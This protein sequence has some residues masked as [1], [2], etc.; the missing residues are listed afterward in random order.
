MQ[1]YNKY[2]KQVSMKYVLHYE[3]IIH[4]MT[5]E[6]SMSHMP[7]IDTS[8]YSKISGELNPH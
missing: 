6:N 4:T 7:N 1:L 8:A 3:K 2:H 5:R